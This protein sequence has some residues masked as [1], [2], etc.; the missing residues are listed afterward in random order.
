MGST[1]AGSCTL[2]VLYDESCGFCTAV[3]AWLVRRGGGRLRAEPIGSPTGDQA[4]RDLQ[5]E[6]RYATVHV[7]DRHGR[8]WS[9]PASLPVLA[10][11]TP[12]LG[13]AAVPLELLPGATR[14][15]Y[16]WVARHRSLLS[17]LLGT[18]PQW[19][20]AHNGDEVATRPRDGE[21]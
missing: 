12:G 8:R 6:Q 13:W 21:R 10:R 9:G 18:G 4:L 1:G 17:R 2:T 16:D 19:P 3:G 14:A 20:R 15:G 5:R 7:I 11:S